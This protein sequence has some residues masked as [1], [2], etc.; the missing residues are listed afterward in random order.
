MVKPF[1]ISVAV[2]LP[3]FPYF[4]D[5]KN[6]FAVLRVIDLMN[7]YV[8]TEP[9]RAYKLQAVILVVKLNAS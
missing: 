2:S 7:Q 3:V 5:C 8:K 4:T 1:G 6:N 9:F